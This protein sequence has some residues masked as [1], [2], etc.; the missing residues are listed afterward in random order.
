M[1]F[2]AA[3]ELGLALS[4][5]WMV[6][7]SISDAHAGR[8]AGY[9]ALALVRTGHGMDMPSG[10]P[11]IRFVAED[12]LPA[13]KLLIRLDSPERGSAGKDEECG[14]TTVQ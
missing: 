4:W 3:R 13:A 14:T 5:S 9:G 7:D 10:G 8:N 2:R 1:L 12:L 6:G 11:V